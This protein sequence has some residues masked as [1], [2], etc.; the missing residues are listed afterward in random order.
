MPTNQPNKGLPWCGQ[1]VNA[2][3]KGNAPGELV[4][5][6][7]DGGYLPRPKLCPDL[8]QC[9]D[10]YGAGGGIRTLISYL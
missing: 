7:R 2:K 5:S 9:L 3:C 4:F 1:N 6:G 10:E 8:R